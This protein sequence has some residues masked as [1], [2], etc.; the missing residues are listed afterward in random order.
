[1]AA[2]FDPVVA[3]VAAKALIEARR[4]IAQAKSANTRTMTPG[5]EG[6]QGDKG[7]RGDK[8]DTGERGP[9]GEP[10]KDGEPG[11]AGKDGK[12]GQQGEPGERGKQGSKGDTPEHEWS[13]SRLRF[14]KPDGTWGEFVELRGPKGGRGD[15]GRAGGGGGSTTITA[16]APTYIAATAISGHT[17]VTL[18]VTGKALPADPTVAAHAHAVIGISLNAASAG[19]QLTVVDSGLLTHLGWS[20]EPGLPVFIGM[21]GV[22]TQTP[23]SAVWQKVVGVALSATSIVVGLQPAIFLAA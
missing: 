5:P 15:T 7:E 22:I 23:P 2:P 8:G 13:G 6:L 21:D 12:D 19:G 17:V 20:F 4:A 1:M 9:K 10:G 16:D 18:D 3:A 14:E 11:P